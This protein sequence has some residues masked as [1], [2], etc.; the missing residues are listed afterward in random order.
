[1]TRVDGFDSSFLLSPLVMSI[2]FVLPPCTTH[3]DQ[4][5]ETFLKED[6]QGDDRSSIKQ[7]EE[8]DKY[9]LV[10][11]ERAQ[12]WLREKGCFKGIF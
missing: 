1:M 3:E 10:K 6:L 7:G 2:P 9:R 5:I 8:V 11:E 12:C 4:T